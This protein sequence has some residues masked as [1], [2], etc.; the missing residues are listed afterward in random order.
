MDNKIRDPRYD[1]RNIGKIDSV[2]K[3]WSKE[4]EVSSGWSRCSTIPFK[5]PLWCFILDG[6]Y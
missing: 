2:G 3:S 4:M 5:H 6:F 1:L